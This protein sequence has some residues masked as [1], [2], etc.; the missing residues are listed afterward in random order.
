MLY[1][2]KTKSIMENTVVI[3]LFLAVLYCRLLSLSLYGG[4]SE[5]VD[6]FCTNTFMFES[7]GI[8]PSGKVVMWLRVFAIFLIV[9]LGLFFILFVFANITFFEEEYE[10][11]QLRIFNEREQDGMKKWKY[12]LE[13][14]TY[15]LITS[16]HKAIDALKAYEA[17][18]I[19]IF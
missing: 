7:T 4:F 18:S 10:E 2:F 6:V 13:P 19:S 16:G 5:K 14:G 15:K 3:I 11:E 12:M 17:Y 8:G 9:I 1:T